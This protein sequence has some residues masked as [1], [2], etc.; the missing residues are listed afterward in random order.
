LRFLDSYEQASA[1]RN[2]LRQ[3]LTELPQFQQAGHR[4]VAEIT[5]RQRY[6][7]D[8]CPIVAI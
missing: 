3:Q 1:R 7:S 8:Q 6:Y 2:L 4:I 5:L